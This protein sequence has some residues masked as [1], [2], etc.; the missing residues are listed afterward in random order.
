MYAIFN[1]LITVNLMLNLIHQEKI[2]LQPNRAEESPISVH[3]Q[4]IVFS[5]Y[6]RPES[7]TS[8]NENGAAEECLESLLEKDEPQEGLTSADTESET[9]TETEEE[10]EEDDDSDDVTEISE[11][12]T[13]STSMDYNQEPIWPAKLIR[14]PFERDHSDYAMRVGKG[15][16]LKEKANLCMELNDHRRPSVMMTTWVIPMLL[17][18]LLLLLV[19][20][21][22]RPQPAEARHGMGPWGIWQ[23]PPGA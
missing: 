19:L 7:A 11:E 20:L 22:R 10:E 17:I 21:N 5:D 14:E 3:H 15:T 2:D 4:E 23:I 12:E 1:L 9:E 8:S 6:S 13:G 16:I 18:A